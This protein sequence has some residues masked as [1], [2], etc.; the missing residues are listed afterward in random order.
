MGKKQ[1]NALKRRHPILV[2]PSTLRVDSK[3]KS[4][5][6]PPEKMVIESPGPEIAPGAA[7]Q[8][9]LAKEYACS[10]FFRELFRS[11]R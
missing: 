9:G 7:Q 5:V 4:A 6:S 2:T 3:P 10:V 8:L 1:R 11:R